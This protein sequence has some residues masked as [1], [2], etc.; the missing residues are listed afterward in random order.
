MGIGKVGGPVIFLDRDGVLNPLVLNP[1]NGRMESPLTVGEFRLA[2]GVLPALLQLQTAGYS[3]ILV[4]NQPNYA[5][6]KCSLEALHTIHA[7]LVRELDAAAIHFRRFCYCPHHPCGVVP[8]YAGVCACRK[9]SPQFLL[10]ARDDFRL[11][12]AECWMIGDQLTDMECGRA[13]GVRTIHIRDEE[14]RHA[15]RDVDPG[16]DFFAKN[17]AEAVTVVLAHPPL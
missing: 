13:A 5:L 6:G 10:E 4:S 14:T 16:A 3:L 12:L 11:K 17:L 1:A 15:S 2:E 8:G 7:G 9:P